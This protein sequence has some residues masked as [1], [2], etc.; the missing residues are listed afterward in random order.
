MLLNFLDTDLY[1][2]EGKAL[3]NFQSTLPI[4]MGDLAKEITKDP[5]NFAFA[6][7]TDKSIKK[8]QM[9]A[10]RLQEKATLPQ[11]QAKMGT[12]T[13]VLSPTAW[14]NASLQWLEKVR[15][16]LRDLIKFLVGAK[17]PWF[18]VDI[19]DTITYDG[20]STG[21]TMKVTY[22]QRVMDY[23]AEH[24]DLPVL[25]KIYNIER[26][27]AQD[28]QELERILWEE[29]GNKQEYDRLT[30]DRPCGAN[31]AMFIRSVIGVDHENAIRRFSEF[32]SGAQLNAEQEEFISTIITYVCENG[33][34]TK[35]IVV[36][37][38]PFDEQLPIFE[39]Q[40]M[41]LANYIDNIHNAI[42]PV[43]PYSFEGSAARIV[44]D[45][46]E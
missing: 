41:P 22:R 32:L 15:L 26:L 10:E 29:L 27:T 39:E 7:I 8:V 28:V 6:G 43:R 9:I 25:G 18:V 35:E 12:I 21:I 40:M 34:I 23:L 36:N 19:G 42:I 3:N 38:S 30:S 14:Q 1:E 33:D 2:R 46:E 11:V 4:P 24:R 20:E 44:A 16:D 17:N 5:Y 13:E 45:E 31:V 37:E